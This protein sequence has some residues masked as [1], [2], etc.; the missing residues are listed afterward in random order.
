MASRHG[1]H[2]CQEDKRDELFAYAILWA[3]HPV[4]VHVFDKIF[5]APL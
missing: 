1:R 3:A 4:I 2:G 5:A